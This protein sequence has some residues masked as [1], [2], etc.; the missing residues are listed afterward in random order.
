MAATSTD[1]V[2]YADAAGSVTV[3]LG[4]ATQQDTGAAG[5]DTIVNVEN[6]TGSDFADTLT[7][8]AGNNVLNGLAGDDRINGK[9]GVDDL[10][11]GAGNDTLVLDTQFGFGSTFNGGD[12][13]DTLELHNA[14]GQPSSNSDQFPAGIPSTSYNA[15]GS[16]ISL[17]ERVDFQSTA[18]NQLS[19]VIG[20]GGTG[21]FASQLGAAG[22]SDSAT[23]VGGAGYD[24]MV[25]ISNY[26]TASA[27]PGGFVL[28][29]PAFSYT[30]WVAGSRAYLPGDKV[31]VINNGNA[32]GTIN[33]SVHDGIQYLSGGTGTVTIN[34]TEGMEYLTGGTGKNSM[35]LGKGGDDTL[36]LS[37]LISNQLVSG[38]VTP[39]A[40]ATATGEDVTYD[41][42]DGFDFLLLGGNVN[43]KGTVANIEGLYLAPSY[44]NN[45]ANSVSQNFTKVTVS[46]ATWAQMAPNLEIDG[47]GSVTV[48]LAAGD[49]FDGS[50]YTFDAGSNVTFTVSGSTGDDTIIGTDNGDT[51]GGDDGDDTLT[52]GGGAD[53]FELSLGNDVVSDFTPGSRQDRPERSGHFELRA[54]AALPVA[55]RQRCDFQP[56]LRRRGQH[57]QP[58][59][60]R[61]FQPDRGRLRLRF[62]H[63]S[64][65]PHGH[66]QCRH[67]V[68]RERQRYAE[69][70]G[71]QRH[72][73]C[74]RWQGYDF[75]RRRRRHDRAECS[76]RL[77]QHYR[78]R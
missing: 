32:N 40:E 10:Q 61:Q 50:A 54:V 28:D 2:T 60:H 42:G 57:D 41:G 55:E 4:K 48:N 53:L 29:A 19:M 22:I 33:G 27:P 73:P 20:F 58:Q 24:S 69:R 6:L 47:V 63:R 65:Q 68:R 78:W 71:R 5:L 51:L 17:I 9:G 37:N 49:S 64:A 31:F 21:P 62:S 59:G 14:A 23:L 46:G 44:S 70:P 67:P 35:L 8:T 12:D 15:L 7:G 75:R 72:H 39:L 1:T 56:A 74:G 43:F 11:G 34:G 66:G 30:N 52:G 36:A 3:D 38:V 45:T 25:L 26:S 18:G 13:I 16:T 76:C 77:R